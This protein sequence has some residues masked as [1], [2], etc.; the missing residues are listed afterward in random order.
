MRWKNRPLEYQNTYELPH[1][2]SM[3]VDWDNSP[4]F[5]HFLHFLHPI[6][7]LRTCVWLYCFSLALPL[8]H[9]PFQINF[10]NFPGEHGPD[11]PSGTPAFS[12]ST[13]T[14]AIPP[15][16]TRS[17]YVPTVPIGDEQR[18]PWCHTLPAHHPT[19]RAIDEKKSSGNGEIVRQ[20]FCGR[21][22]RL[23]IYNVIGYRLRR[24]CLFAGNRVGTDVSAGRRAG[25]ENDRPRPDWLTVPVVAS[26]HLQRRRH[27]HHHHHQRQYRQQPHYEVVGWWPTC[28]QTVKLSDEEL[29]RR[30]SVLSSS[31]PLQVTATCKR[32][33][34]L[35][36]LEECR[37]HTHL[38]SLGHWASSWIHHL[39]WMAKPTVTLPSAELC[40]LAGNHLP[41]R[42]GQE[43]ELASVGG[44]IS[45]RHTRER[46]PIWV[47]A[48]L[49]GSRRVRFSPM[50][51]Y[52]SV[53]LFIRTIA[54]KP[55]QL[56]CHQTWHRNVPPWVLGSKGQRSRPR[57]TKMC[58]RG[59][60]TLV[61]A[62]FF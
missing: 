24:R 52:V 36:T 42:W 39:W 3:S 1:C 9:A 23:S 4:L 2:A 60:C 34:V 15:A 56:Q 8:F 28:C 18:E 17:C 61:S 10:L 11:S 12:G 59:F 16:N 58:R 7:S 21:A 20:G 13:F 53:C 48:G 14:T 40:P 43:T 62:G 47:I 19:T 27:H 35:Y 50:F 30:S 51:V 29:R 46:S 5:W 22:V 55:M 33:R 38:P 26:L 44:Y 54:Q 31:L 25:A 32:W 6:G 37:R 49:D 57:S 41:S 45:R